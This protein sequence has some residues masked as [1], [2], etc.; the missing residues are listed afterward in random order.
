MTLVDAVFLIDFLR[1]KREARS[2]MTAAE[3]TGEILHVT[4]TVAF[5]VLVGAYAKGGRDLERA[6]ELIRRLSFLPFDLEDVEEA[7]QAGAELRKRGTPIGPLDT[8]NAGAALH[9]HDRFLTR[10][11]D[12]ARVPRLVVES[13]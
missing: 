4:P 1:G 10:D 11:A 8:L 5:E 13:Y 7:A 12:Y 9:R 2:R 6:R 3:A